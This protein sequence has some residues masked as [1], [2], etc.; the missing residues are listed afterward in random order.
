MSSR[1]PGRSAV[2]YQPSAIGNP[3]KE[4][5]L[6]ILVTGSMA[7]DY[8]MDFPGHFSD[9]ILPDKVH[10][11]SVSFMVQGLKRNRGGVAGNIAHN[12]QLLGAPVGILGTVGHD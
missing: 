2:S 6:S 12:L 7:Y 10:M 1:S 5:R 9:H 8:I 11:L 4:R 3:Q